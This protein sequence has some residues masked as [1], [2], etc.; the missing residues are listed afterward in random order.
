MF[1]VERES[2]SSATT[3]TLLPRGRCLF[4]ANC[5]PVKRTRC[6]WQS[7]VLGLREKGGG[8]G[9]W[10]A[11]DCVQ[12]SGLVWLCW[13][14]VSAAWVV[15]FVLKVAKLLHRALYSISFYLAM[16]WYRKFLEK[17]NVCS[18][19]FEFC[20]PRNVS[21]SV[22]ATRGETSCSI[23]SSC[24]YTHTHLH[25]H[26]HTLTHTHTHSLT[27]TLTHHTH[28]HH[29]HTHSHTHTHTHTHTHSLKLR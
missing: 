14:L 13:N 1:T 9:G 5:R 8:V 20:Y 16:S 26:T 19:G 12:C 29:T 2:R 28:T 27:H 21:S 23:H 11:E 15:L 3:R 4:T 10:V 25:T 17:I 22:I 24:A 6:M 7:F 18:G